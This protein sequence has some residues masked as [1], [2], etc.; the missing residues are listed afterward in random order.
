[1][2]GKRT[3][4]GQRRDRQ[5]S[6]PAAG[7]KPAGSLRRLALIAVVTVAVLWPVLGAG[8]LDQWDDPQTIFRNP[9]LNP[10]TPGSIAK[11][12]DWRQPHMDLWVP[13]TYTAWGAIAALTR[14]A[15]RLAE[16]ERVE[17]LFS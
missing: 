6:E 17:R 14:R 16:C 15:W 11:Y 8:Y 1:M 5:P 9:D 13:A 2:G 4:S 7:A 3:G 12:W 10:P